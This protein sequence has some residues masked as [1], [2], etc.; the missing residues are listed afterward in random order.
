MKLFPKDT[1]MSPEEK[2]KC[3][4]KMKMNEKSEDSNELVDNTITND[5]TKEDSKDDKKKKNQESNPTEAAIG[6]LHMSK[7]ALEG[8]KYLP[9]DLF[10]KEM[11]K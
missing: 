7:K 2:E 3:D 6:L 9:K 10:I 4:N 8:E 1:K 11:Q 5:S